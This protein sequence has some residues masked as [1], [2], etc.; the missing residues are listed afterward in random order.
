[1]K[2]DDFSPERLA[3]DLERLGVMPHAPILVGFSGG[4]DSTA[5]LHALSRLKWRAV[6]A[7]HINHRLQPLAERW[8]QHAVSAARN[9]GV[10]CEVVAV[11]VHATDEGTE[12][13]ARAARYEAMAAHMREGE[14][15]V[16]AHHAHDQ[17]ET[18]LFQLL[19]G[20]G[21]RGA[22]GMV[23]VRPWGPGRLVRPLLH[24][25]RPAL[26]AYVAREGVA[27]VEDP[28]N[29]ETR[30]ARNYLRQKVWPVIEQRWPRGYQAM[31]RATGHFQAA[32]RLLEAYLGD[33]LRRC[34]DSSGDLL[35]PAF[36]ALSRDAQ[37]FVLRRW[38]QLQG[39]PAVSDRKCQEV[40]DAL[41][42][43]PRSHHQVLRLGGNHVM[44]RY[45]NRVSCVA[46]EPGLEPVASGPSGE[47]SW[48]PPSDYLIGGDGPR[49]VVHEARGLGLRADRLVG[50]TLT[51]SRRAP[52]A[53]VF[54][55]GRGHR[56]LKKFLQELGIPPWER[57]AVVLVFDGPALIAIP[58]FWLSTLYGA[59]PHERG[60]ALS[61]ESPEHL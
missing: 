18:L 45:R 26:A 38:I 23:P 44:R 8:G 5:L 1:M 37:P 54:I 10:I 52:G 2:D 42:T 28:S 17:A 41:V 58:G 13:A 61:V 19:R 39:G 34:R 35:I 30:F 9:M 7:L 47:G 11:T 56:S 53:R 25:G 49:L 4:L 57:D 21:L 48:Q 43:V 29:R 51:I 60:W 36:L 12:A 46:A 32:E 16:V 15:L 59:G 20:T 27:F 24:I 40:L 3:A 14:S 50:K 6:R 33:D 55:P 22:G 31:D